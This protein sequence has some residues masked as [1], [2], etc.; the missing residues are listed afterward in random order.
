MSFLNIT[1]QDDLAVLRLERGKVNAI[2]EA[3]V[4]EMQSRLDELEK[5][6]SV[7]AIIFTGAGSFFSFGFDVPELYNYTREAF[8]DFL[9]KFTSLHKRIF[10]FPRPVV[11]A[12][13]GHA[14][15]GGCMLAGACD[16]RLMVTGKARISLNE[17]TFGSAVFSSSVEIMK[18]WVGPRVAQ[19]ILFGGEMYSA[20]TAKGFGLIDEVV[21]QEQLPRAAERVAHKFASH[22]PAAFAQMKRLLRKPLIDAADRQE[23]E[24]I[25]RFVDIWYSPNTRAQLRKVAIRN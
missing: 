3:V 24:E 16:Y 17:I 4:D 5:N 14:V 10:L 18:Y 21:T 20:E 15:A 25:D 11:A 7:R 9:L 22:D 1:F 6:E 12:L 19:E 23:R 8:T 2:N 13:N